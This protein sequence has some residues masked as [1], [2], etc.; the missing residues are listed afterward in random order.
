MSPTLGWSLSLQVPTPLGGSSNSDSAELVYCHE[1]LHLRDKL[2][3][4]SFTAKVEKW[5]SDSD[6]DASSQDEADL[7]V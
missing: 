7:A 1:A 3:K 6:S 4:A 2:Q 5:V